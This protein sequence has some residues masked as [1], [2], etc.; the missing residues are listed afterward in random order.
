M[1]TRR[2][3]DESISADDQFSPPA[4]ESG[5]VHNLSFALQDN[6]ISSS[7]P[8]D[9][10]QAMIDPSWKKAMEDK[11]AAFQRNHIWDLVSLPA[12]KR[13]VGCR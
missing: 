3:K 2:N 9:Y 13:V 11:L 1:Y 12:R 7:I 8:I 10:K 5:I 4:P 6:M